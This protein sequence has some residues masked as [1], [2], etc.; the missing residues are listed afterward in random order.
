MLLCHFHQ[1]INFFMGFR[2][3][4][5]HFLGLGRPLGWR[6]NQDGLEFHRGRIHCRPELTEEFISG[7]L[8]CRHLS[9]KSVG[10]IVWT[11][12]EE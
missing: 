10:Y 4:Q 7:S 5:Y 12:Y 6:G 11:V 1:R 8:A 2:Y 9:K 3:I